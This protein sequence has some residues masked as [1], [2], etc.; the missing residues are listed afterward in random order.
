MYT[1]RP[2]DQA[3]SIR[4]IQLCPSPS[5]KGRLIIKLHEVSLDSSPRFE[6]LSYA[7]EKQTPDQNISCDGAEF[8]VTATIKAALQRLR[9]KARSR[10][11]WIDQICINQQ[12]VKEKSQQ[13]ALMADVY[14]TAKRV[15]VWLGTGPAADK[16]LKYVE[17]YHLCK[18]LPF[19]GYA[20]PHKVGLKLEHRLGG[21]FQRSVVTWRFKV[22]L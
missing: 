22:L 5:S 8:L 14:S 7:W 10:W 20:I 12:C 15:I 3:R 18:R 17:L 21:E 2:L 11:L 13:V 1:Y 9:H 16:L 6:A 19:A 4:T